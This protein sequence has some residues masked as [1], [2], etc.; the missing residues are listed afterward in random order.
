MTE[1]RRT[2]GYHVHQQPSAGLDI[3]QQALLPVFQ[4]QCQI[5]FVSAACQ[6]A[7]DFAGTDTRLCQRQ[8]HEKGRYLSE[9][10][11]GNKSRASTDF[12][13]MTE[14]AEPRHTGQRIDRLLAI[15]TVNHRAIAGLRAGQQLGRRLFIPGFSK[16]LLQHGRRNFA[17]AAATVRQSG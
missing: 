10:Q 12:R 3:S 1:G 9:R 17:A 7:V 2:I 5:P 8:C 15:E 13:Q 11:L 16:N 6:I 4:L 14:Q